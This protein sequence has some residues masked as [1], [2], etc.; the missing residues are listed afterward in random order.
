M[1]LATPFLPSCIAQRFSVFHHVA[2]SVVSS[3][4]TVAPFHSRSCSHNLAHY[5]QCND[6]AQSLFTGI[7]HSKHVTHFIPRAPHSPHSTSPSCSADL[8]SLQSVKSNQLPPRHRSRNQQCDI[9][10]RYLVGWLDVEHHKRQHRLWQSRRRI[11]HQSKRRRTY[12]PIEF[13]HFLRRGGGMDEGGTRP[14]CSVNCCAR[15]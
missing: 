14:G 8:D 13:L 9:Q 15:V 5:R 2:A 3:R 1:C 7:N 10:L 4:S 11:H 12:Y 6:T